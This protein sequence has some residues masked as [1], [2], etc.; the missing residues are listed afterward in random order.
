MS[1]QVLLVELQ[2]STNY[3]DVIAANDQ[4]EQTQLDVN[5]MNTIGKTSPL[6]RAGQTINQFLSTLL[7]P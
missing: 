5:S 1:V 2:H 7:I 4:K 6:I 3:F